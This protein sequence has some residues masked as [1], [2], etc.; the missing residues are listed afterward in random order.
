[1][2]RL[3]LL[4][5]LCLQPF[6][7]PGQVVQFLSVPTAG[8][9]SRLLLSEESAA[10]Q[11]NPLDLQTPRIIRPD[12]VPNPVAGNPAAAAGSPPPRPRPRPPAAIA[13]PDQFA[14]GS[15]ALPGRT[16]RLLDNLAEALL[17]TPGTSVLISGH[18]DTSG[19]AAA[20]TS[21]SFRRA[22]AARDHLVTQRGVSGARIAVIGLGS[23]APMPGLPG[24]AAEHR[25]IQIQRMNPR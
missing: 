19:T 23:E 5:A 1:M 14:P 25:R 17:T 18:T 15:V 2:K 12:L 21:L 20:N 3:F 6:P 16:M 7:A 13:L 10:E 11:D 9:I 22:Q 4:A 24:T 8:E